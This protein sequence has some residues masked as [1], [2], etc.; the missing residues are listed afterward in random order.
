MYSFKKKKT[1]PC[2]LYGEI[3]EWSHPHFHTLIPT[4]C[5]LALG[6][7]ALCTSHWFKVYF[8]SLCVIITK[9]S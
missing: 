1:L 7:T 9:T 6:K 3:F 8:L 2:E 4:P 5:V